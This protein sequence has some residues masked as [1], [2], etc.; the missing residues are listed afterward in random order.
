MTK[1]VVAELIL[2]LL[3]FENIQRY[4]EY[5]KKFENHGSSDMSS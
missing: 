1:T 5:V 2:H 3:N 4:G